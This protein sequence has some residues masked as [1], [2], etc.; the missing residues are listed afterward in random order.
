MRRQLQGLKWQRASQLKKTA[1]CAYDGE[2][3]LEDIYAGVPVIIGA[4]GVRK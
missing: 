2:Y 3:E 4:K 1:P